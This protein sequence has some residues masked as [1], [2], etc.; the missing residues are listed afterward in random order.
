MC[1][2]GASWLRV[3]SVDGKCD[4]TPQNELLCTFEKSEKKGKVKK[5]IF[6]S[7]MMYFVQI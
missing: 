7:I 4:P 3:F 5:N 6:F 1:N 2:V